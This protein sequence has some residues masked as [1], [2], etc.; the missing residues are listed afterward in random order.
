MFQPLCGLGSRVPPPAGATVN[1]VFIPGGTEVGIAM[2]A[3]M[4]REDVFGP[5]ADTF[6]P[7]RWLEDE[8]ETTI[9]RERVWDLTFSTGRSSCL[10]KNIALME[11]GKALFEVSWWEFS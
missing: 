8:N 11:L 2:Y 9:S 1:G 7:E 4:R 6:R 10:G 3:M 5:D